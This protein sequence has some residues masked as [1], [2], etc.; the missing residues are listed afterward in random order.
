MNNLIIIILEKKIETFIYSR[1]LNN[2]LILP[3]ERAT[4]ESHIHIKHLLMVN[5]PKPIYV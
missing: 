1:V 3:R 5:F 4:L 2:R